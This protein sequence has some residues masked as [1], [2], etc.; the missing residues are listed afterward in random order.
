MLFFW[1]RGLDL[2]H[3]R[4]RERQQAHGRGVAHLLEAQERLDVA[5]RR[6]LGAHH[7]HHV[8]EGHQV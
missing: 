5:V 8:V 6:R 7:A 4:R 1:L 3:A 2:R